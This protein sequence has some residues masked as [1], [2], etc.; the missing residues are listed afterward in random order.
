MVKGTFN[1]SYLCKGK[2]GRRD[3]ENEAREEKNVTCEEL[4]E[5]Y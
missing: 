2:K 4:K 5:N 1:S 3:A